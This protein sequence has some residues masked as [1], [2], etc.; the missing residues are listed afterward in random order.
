MS[1]DVRPLRSDDVAWLADLHNAAFAD[2]A[3]PAVLDASGLGFY[4]DETGVDPALSRVAFVDGVP[5]RVDPADHLLQAVA[6]PAG[7][8]SI[9]LRYDDPWIRAGLVGSGAALA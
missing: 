4:L 1:V 6:V 7:R 3:V 8:H 9:V 5:A 2:Y